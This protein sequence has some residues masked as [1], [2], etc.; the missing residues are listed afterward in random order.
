MSKNFLEKDM[1]RRDF[2]KLSGKGIAGL[3]VS[4]SFLS[5]VGCTKKDVESGKVS[6]AV[7][8]TGVLVSYRDRCVGCQRC[9]MACSL[10]NDGKVQTYLSR[11][12]VG[13]SIQ[14]GDNG[15]GIDYQTDDGM[16]GN[17][18]FT[19][20]TCKQCEKPSCGEACPQKAIY[21]DEKTGI[22]K[23]DSKKCVGCGA[24]TSACPWNMPTIDEETKKSTKCI[25]CGEC[26]SGCPTGALRIVTWE[27]AQK[28]LN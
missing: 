8:P 23:I 21:G 12:K 16:Y 11:V 5:L 14:F 2:M 26:A 17:F 13:Q 18:T 22:R 19:Q 15:A 24:C 1:S 7:I 25:S 20:N 10:M 27:E 3:M 4:A 28:V 9:E 6:F